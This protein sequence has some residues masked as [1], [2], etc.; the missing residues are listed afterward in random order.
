M[1]RMIRAETGAKPGADYSFAHN[2]R[3]SLTTRHPIDPKIGCVFKVLLGTESNRRR[4]T[5][6]LSGFAGAHPS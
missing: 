3:G 4:L 5:A 2:Y 1:T 6:D